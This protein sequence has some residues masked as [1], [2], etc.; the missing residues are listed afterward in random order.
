MF[1]AAAFVVTVVI[2]AMRYKWRERERKAQE[3]YKIVEQII[4]KVAIITAKFIT[5]CFILLLRVQDSSSFKGGFAKGMP[6]A[7]VNATY[8][9]L[10]PRV[11]YMIHVAN[12]VC[13]LA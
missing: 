1:V 9:F 2:A 3:V 6:V 11:E 12:I 8:R 10:L 7:V 4:G 13:G 5:L